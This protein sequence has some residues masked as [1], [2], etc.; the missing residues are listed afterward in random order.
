MIRQ[1]KKTD[2]EL[3][4]KYLMFAGAEPGAY[5]LHKS[6]LF[7]INPLAFYI[8]DKVG[9]RS[10]QIETIDKINRFDGIAHILVE[11]KGNER[12]ED[13]VFPNTLAIYWDGRTQ[14][15]RSKRIRKV[16]SKMGQ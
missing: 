4:D 1:S 10:E 11:F 8:I 16:R 12:V 15:R 7:K 13:H 14:A 3:M 9:S 5:K 6:S 2:W